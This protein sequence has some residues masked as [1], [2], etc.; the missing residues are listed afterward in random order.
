MRNKS[1]GRVNVRA[2]EKLL[3]S[4][5]D[6]FSTG[7]CVNWVERSIIRDSRDNYLPQK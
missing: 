1:A 5:F 3:G 4:F 2:I 6:L 7:V